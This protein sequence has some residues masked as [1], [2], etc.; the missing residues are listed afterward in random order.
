M[1]KLVTENGRTIEYSIEHNKVFL[2][3]H[4]RPMGQW[5]SA[6]LTNDELDQVIRM[7]QDAKLEVGG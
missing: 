6:L 3:L 5:C 2:E 1:W 4:D 7:L